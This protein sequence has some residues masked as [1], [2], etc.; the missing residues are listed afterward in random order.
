MPRDIK[1]L[2]EGVDTNID[3]LQT[4]YL[5][6]ADRLIIGQQWYAPAGTVAAFGT[7]MNETTAPSGHTETN[8]HVFVTADYLSRP[9]AGYAPG[10][11]VLQ[12]MQG[13]F[14]G[15]QTST[16]VLAGFASQH[17]AAVTVPA[18]YLRLRVWFIKQ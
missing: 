18:G 10:G 7:Y 5:K 17:S 3:G 8:S 14:W 13:R 12:G 11:N 16:T 6:R 1:A 15:W 4:V 2:A 9:A